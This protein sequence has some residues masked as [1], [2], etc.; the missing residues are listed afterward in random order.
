MSI[1][2]VAK[3]AGV[4]VATVSRVINDLDNVRAE[5][6]EQVRAAMSEMGYT[7]PRVKRGPKGG[8]RRTLP[9]FMR[10]GQFAV[11]TVG[12]QQNWLG[13]PVMS[14]VVTG[15]MRA[16]KELDIRPVLDEMPDPD[17]VPSVI[18]Q[19]EVDGAIVFF[20]SGQPIANLVRLAQHLPIVWAMGGEDSVTAIDHV[21]ADNH[22]VGHLAYDYLK[23]RGCKTIASLQWDWPVVRVRAKAFAEAASQDGTQAQQ[24]TVQFHLPAGQ[25]YGGGIATGNTFDAAIDRMLAS[26]PRPDGL[27]VP[28]DSITAQIYPL[29]IARGIVPGR[30]IQIVSCDYESERI[31]AL[32][33]RPATIDIHSEQIGRWAVRQLMS[34][35][36]RPDEPA[37][38]V[39]LAPKLVL[40]QGRS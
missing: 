30:D 6:I 10:T 8:P 37:V 35:L 23:T 4:S 15:V 22:G 25:R 18:R 39:Q 16:A 26:N 2:A 24:Y 20:M 12:A 32:N 14:S 9:S 5:T 31:S 40:P 27:F 36:E 21:T 17:I 28:T 3:R 34:R 11:L 13:V 7:P 1:V 29:L 19:A 38:R 33:P